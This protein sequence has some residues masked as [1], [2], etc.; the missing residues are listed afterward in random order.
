MMK[1]TT[2]FT[3][4][5]GIPELS[6]ED[7]PFQDPYAGFAPMPRRPA[8]APPRAQVNIKFLRTFL[9]LVEER[10]TTRAAQRLGMHKTNVLTQ[11]SRLE[12]AV[13]HQLLERRF[14]PAGKEESGRTQLTAAGRQFL[15]KAIEAVRAHDRLFDDAPI[16]NDPREANRVVASRLIEVA[17]AALRHDL[18]EEQ[19]EKFYA[20]LFG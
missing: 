7:R 18:T 3:A 2:S 20:N 16:E 8:A 5:S 10:N 6:A 17:L 4:G 13:G 12:E 19:R 1:R 11:V 15:P 14:P 9:A